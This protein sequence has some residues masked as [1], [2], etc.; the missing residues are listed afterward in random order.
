MKAHPR[1]PRFK[2]EKEEARWWDAHPEVITAL[3]LKA[4]KEGKIERLPV[5]RGATKIHH[6]PDA[7]R[8]YRKGSRHCRKARLAVPDLHQGTAARGPQ[9]GAQGWLTPAGTNDLHAPRVHGVFGL[10]PFQPA[11]VNWSCHGVIADRFRPPIRR[12]VVS[13]AGFLEATSSSADPSNSRPA[14]GA[15]CDSAPARRRPG[16]AGR[17]VRLRTGKRG[18]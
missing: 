5:M 8:R 9:P 2:S 1:I 17:R 13:G 4:R 6:H 14:S 12:R 3:F 18:R 7:D 16:S 10:N 11:F 15:P